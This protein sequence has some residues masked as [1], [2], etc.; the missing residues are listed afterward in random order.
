MYITAFQNA[1]TYQETLSKS[2]RS[3]GIS[4]EQDSTISCLSFFYG[5]SYAD[6]VTPPRGS[7][8]SIDHAYIPNACTTDALPT[9]T[10]ATSNRSTAANTTALG[11]TTGSTTGST[12]DNRNESRSRE[13]HD[14]VLIQSVRS[15]I[16]QLSV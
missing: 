2:N 8:A 3:M 15:Q 6:N 1:T 13:S 7:S 5:A 10:A 16:V 11:S 4:A 14:A 12:I 9:S